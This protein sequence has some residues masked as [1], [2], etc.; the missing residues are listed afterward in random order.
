[1]TMGSGS[2]RSIGRRQIRKGGE[3]D[4]LID[5]HDRDVV[6]NGIGL[7]AVISYEKAVERRGD[8]IPGA[9]DKNT[10]L[11]GVIHARQKPRVREDH[12]T[13]GLRTHENVE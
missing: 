11:G 12:R 3:V 9:I 6:P 5:E 8:R 4:G 10:R 13:V 2:V 1:M 7:K